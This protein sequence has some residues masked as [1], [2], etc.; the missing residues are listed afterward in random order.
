MEN[1]LGVRGIKVKVMYLQKDDTREMN[2]FLESHNGNIVSI[3]PL[4][5]NEYGTTKVLVTYVGE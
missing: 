2:T 3:Q 5:S 1:L 4:A